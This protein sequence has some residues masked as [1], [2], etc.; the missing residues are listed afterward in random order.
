[1]A[2]MRKLTSLGIT[3]CFILGLFWLAGFLIEFPGF[4]AGAATGETRKIIA[5]SMAQTVLNPDA[6]FLREDSINHDFSKVNLAQSWRDNPSSG[7]L[8]FGFTSDILWVY[9]PLTFATAPVNKRYLVIPYPLLEHVELSAFNESGEQIF[10]SDLSQSRKQQR[11]VDSQNLSFLLP[12]HFVGN[13]D[14]F[15]RV[16][17]TTSMQVPLELWSEDYLITRHIHETLLWGLYFGVIIALIAYNGFLFFS[18]RDLAYCYYS[19][20]LTSSAGIMLCLSGLGALYVWPMDAAFNRHAL[21]FFTGM[22]SLWMLAFTRSFLNWKGFPSAM[23]KSLATGAVV[24][25]G[26]MVFAWFNPVLGAHI[27]AWVGS[28]TIVMS[29]SAGLYALSRG[30]AIARFFVLA[31]TMFAAGASLYLLNVFGWLPVSAFTNHAIQLGSALE[32]IL[33]SLA[34]A[35]RIKEDR[36]AVL[37][38]LQQKH[39][40]DQQLKQMELDV[41]DSAMHDPLTG[42]PNDSLLITRM[43][44]LEQS[45]GDCLFGVIMLQFP[46]MREIAT[47]LGRAMAVPLF[48]KLVRDL[49]HVLS[50]HH[51]AMVIEEKSRA[52]LAV[53]EF[54]TLVFLCKRDEIDAEFVKRFAEHFRSM[55]DAAIDVG[56]ITVNL[57]AFCGIAL[58]PMHGEKAEILLQHASASLEQG[59]R[60]GERVC[61]Y[62]VEIDNYGHRR[63]ALMGA[64]SRA[65]R[66]GELDIYVQPQLDC[67]AMK[68]VGGEIL[69]RWNSA[70]HGNVPT[71]EFIEIAENAGMMPQLSRYVVKRGMLLLKQ[72]HAQGLPVTLSLNLSVHNLVEPDFVAF[73]ED[74]ARELQVDLRFLVMEVTET[75]A[76]ENIDTVIG[77][78]KQLANIGCSI[79]LDDF[80]TG[81]SSLSYL[82]RLPIH[83]LKIDR[84]FINQMRKSDSDL[85]IVENT[86]KL[87][88][89]LHIQ[90]VAEGVEDADMLAIVT[91][92]GCDRVQGYFTGK[93][94]PAEFFSKWALRKAS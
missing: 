91:A 38:A 58:Y 36:L 75:S 68:L 26:L 82:S 74:H 1:M 83:E 22:T 78:L 5:A 24:C 59:H 16:R 44:E 93:P 29:L 15:L 80:G 46:Q 87:A 28:I 3:A 33:L 72:L 57:D 25:L 9:L 37:I 55:Y 7:V 14:L 84:S 41:R 32:A 21:T 10:E 11:V 69:L 18:V 2:A 60:N 42:M 56:N 92:L 40:I 70:K 47:S 81:Y 86:V 51:N 4:Y 94:M 62:S 54:G 77:T 79:A 76:S 52:Y 43:K 35:H 45:A 61:V 65:I 85:R 50:E 49:N 30:V 88:R 66:D 12:D 39:A 67:F 71:Q 6:R 17:S 53:T 23:N 13:I 89:T 31:F 19:L 73:V 27:S 34:L 64:L 48:N 63:L 90:T 8:S 20:Y